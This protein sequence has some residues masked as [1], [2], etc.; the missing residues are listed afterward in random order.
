MIRSWAPRRAC[1]FSNGHQQAGVRT[2]N[3]DVVAH[4]GQAGH[5]VIEKR[6]SRLPTLSSGD[7]D[8]NSEFRDC[9]RSDGRFVVVGDQRLEVDHGSLGV[10]QHTGVE[11]SG[12]SET[13][14]DMELTA[15]RGKVIRPTTVNVVAAEQRLDLGSLAR[16]QV[17]AGQRCGHDA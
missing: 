5:D 2:C 9:D 16:G 6:S 17:R 4:D 13:L 10:D 15:Q 7:L 3:L 12:R 1:T 11:E 8:A 14:L